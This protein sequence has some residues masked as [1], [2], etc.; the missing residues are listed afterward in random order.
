[1]SKNASEYENGNLAHQSKARDARHRGAGRDEQKAL[2]AAM[3]REFLEGVAAKATLWDRR[4]NWASHP[5]RRSRGSW[6]FRIRI[7]EFV[8]ACAEVQF[9]AK[10]DAAPGQLLKTIARMHRHEAKLIDQF[11]RLTHIADKSSPG[12]IPVLPKEAQ[13]ST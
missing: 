13:P 4:Y 9:L 10:R 11:R 7:L 1:M 8:T 2:I 3:Q 5:S 6:W 12:A